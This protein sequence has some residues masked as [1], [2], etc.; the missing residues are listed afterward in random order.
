MSRTLEWLNANSYRRYPFLEDSALWVDGAFQL[1]LNFLL[2]F[3]LTLQRTDAQGV[4]QASLESIEVSPGRLAL[5]VTFLVNGVSLPMIVPAVATMP[6][7]ARGI[8][9]TS[10]FAGNYTIT[11]GTGVQDFAA[12]QSIGVHLLSTG[13]ATIDPVLLPL[14]TGCRVDSVQAV[15]GSVLQGKITVQPG[16]NCEPTAKGTILRFQAGT[17]FGAG[18]ACQSSG[19][20]VLSCGNA[21]LWFCGAHAS[22][23]G[24]VELEG[25]PGVQISPDPHN[26][27]TIL[28]KSSSA[29]A[30]KD[31]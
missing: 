5:V 10:E 2:D 9:A 24:N 13:T 20:G 3:Q 30:N 12:N 16:Y 27:N 19:P 18:Q 7:T 26:P 28:I 1:A 14:A 31:C 6:Y 21:F 25:G 22:Q 4:P 11:F 8:F 29:L 17:G 15:G 23:D